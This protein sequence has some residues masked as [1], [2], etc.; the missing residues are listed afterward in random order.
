MEVQTTGRAMRY[1]GK[2][3]GKN[4]LGRSTGGKHKQTHIKI[5]NSN[6]GPLENLH[7]FEQLLVCISE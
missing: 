3:F 7:C 2:V 6:T 5:D 1:G 4:R